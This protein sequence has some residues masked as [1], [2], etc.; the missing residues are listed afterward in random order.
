MVNHVVCYGLWLL[1][2][3]WLEL[4][5]MNKVNIDI[6][7]YNPNYMCYKISNMTYKCKGCVYRGDRDEF[8]NNK[9]GK[10]A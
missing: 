8:K 6:C 3:W 5:E 9:S 4:M 1:C 7:K 10:M 2:V